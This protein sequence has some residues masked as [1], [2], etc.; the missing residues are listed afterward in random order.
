MPKLSPAERAILIAQ[1][2]TLAALEDDPKAY[3]RVIAILD[4]GYEA[5]YEEHIEGLSEPMTESECRD[6]RDILWIYFRIKCAKNK[7]ALA[8]PGG[9]RDAHGGLRLENYEPK[10]PGFDGNN[11]PRQLAYAKF[12]IEQGQF[13]EAAPIV[14][15][16]GFQPDYTNM[17][18]MYRAW[19]SPTNLSQ[20][21]AD[22]LLRA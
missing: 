16:H 18:E 19:G 10:F 21:E 22:D 1:Y 12:L 13:L 8:D 9:D 15:S 6:V 7:D 17:L 4:R 14:N 5:E 11:Q 3:E 20:E 2:R